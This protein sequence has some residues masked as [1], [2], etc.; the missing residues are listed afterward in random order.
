M[1]ISYEDNCIWEWILKKKT[2]TFLK[3]IYIIIL[4]NKPTGIVHDKGDH[5]LRIYIKL[6]FKVKI[7][8]E[9]KHWCVKIKF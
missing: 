5:Q 7:Y 2:R 3:F 9:I 8:E 6:Y 4:Q 1:T